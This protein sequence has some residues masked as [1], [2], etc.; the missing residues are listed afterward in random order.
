MEDESILMCLFF[1]WVARTPPARCV[2]DQIP[3]VFFRGLARFQ[4][5]SQTLG[6][7]SKKSIMLGP[8]AKDKKIGREIGENDDA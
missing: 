7:G 4:T 5:S 1:S 3:V 2:L 6:G 8:T